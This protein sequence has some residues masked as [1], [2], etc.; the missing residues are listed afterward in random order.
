M[1][2][3]HP[4]KNNSKIHCYFSPGAR[5]RHARATRRT[6]YPAVHCTV[7]SGNF[8]VPSWQNCVCLPCSAPADTVCAASL[9]HPAP[10]G[11]APPCPALHK[12]VS[13]LSLP[14]AGRGGSWR[15]AVPP[16]PYSSGP[17]TAG[18]PSS[19]AGMPE[20]RRA[21]RGPTPQ[22]RGT[23]IPRLDFT[24]HVPSGAGRG[25]VGSARRASP[26]QLPSARPLPPP[27]RSAST[28]AL[29]VQ[30]YR[31]V[32]NACRVEL[33]RDPAG[34]QG[35][36]CRHAFRTSPGQYLHR[37]PWLLPRAPPPLRAARHLGATSLAVID[38]GIK[39]CLRC[40]RR[41]WNG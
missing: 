28:T 29:F 35:D 4:P 2:T 34:Q 6:N 12:N 38:P 24:V 17:A 32:G 18:R 25:G 16:N 21:M 7:I 10:P 40:R 13:G 9:L 27:P 1:A 3:L 22:L 11:A 36:K 15:V 8:A 41:R 30:Y 31:F 33:F 14:G 26:C 23:G 5:A 19:R 39:F 20:G 37:V